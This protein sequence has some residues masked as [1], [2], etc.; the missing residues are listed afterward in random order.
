M[1]KPDEGRLGWGS[2]RIGFR[3]E[4]VLVVPLTPTLSQGERESRRP[5][6]L[7]LQAAD[8]QADDGCDAGSDEDDRIGDK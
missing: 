3:M 1:S 2:T 7:F 6:A 5:A 4:R 8:D